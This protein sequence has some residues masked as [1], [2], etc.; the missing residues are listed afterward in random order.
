MLTLYNKTIQT[1]T[2]SNEEDNLILAYILVDDPIALV[3]Y[4]WC[5]NN[6]RSIQGLPTVSYI[7]RAGSVLREGWHSKFRMADK[8]WG[9]GEGGEAYLAKYCKRVKT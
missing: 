1:L 4:T 5:S 8:I 9:S 3:L 7:L 2:L 6:R